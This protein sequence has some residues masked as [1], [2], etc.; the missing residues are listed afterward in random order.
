M[1]TLNQLKPYQQARILQIHGDDA[2]SMRLMEMGLIDGET[3]EFLGSAPLGDPLE[4]TV[5]GYRLSLRVQ[6]AE[7]VEI[8][9]IDS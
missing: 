3:I 7:R 9:I 1:L 6:E 2:I 4:F 5:R 8:E